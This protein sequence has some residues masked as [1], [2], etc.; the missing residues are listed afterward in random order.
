MPFFYTPLSENARLQ[1][2]QR[3]DAAALFHLVDSNR[4]HLGRWL[5]WVNNVHEVKDSE[6]FIASRLQI[7]A[8]N[9]GFTAGVWYQDQLAGLIE[10]HRIHWHDR[11]SSLGYYLGASFQGHG[12]MTIAAQAVT[13]YGFKV[14]KLNRIEILAAAENKRSRAV[15]ERLHFHHEG[16]L[17]QFE[18]IGDQYLDMAVYAMLAAE[19]QQQAK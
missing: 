3:H 8:E 14:L 16:T 13:D 12:L 4:E 17:R 18:R 10:L 11:R 1:L 2:L 5:N 9:G 6:A 15:A 19:W 7:T